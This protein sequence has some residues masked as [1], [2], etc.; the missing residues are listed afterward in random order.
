MPYANGIDASH[1]LQA[2]GMRAI[3]SYNRVT[4]FAQRFSE[5]LEDITEPGNVGIPRALDPEDSVVTTI[6]RVVAEHAEHKS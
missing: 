5:E 6:E 2:A 3:E 1:K 4:R